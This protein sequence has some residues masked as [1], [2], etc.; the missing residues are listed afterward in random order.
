MASRDRI[1]IFDRNIFLPRGCD[2]KDLKY[3]GSVF[4]VEVERI[5]YATSMVANLKRNVV[6]RFKIY[7]ALKIRSC[8][9]EIV[10]PLTNLSR[11]E[12]PVIF[13]NT[14]AV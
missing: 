7:V 3:V 1:G 5:C 11:R 6:Y 14:T 9:L 2:L 10:E 12:G 13:E 8:S 4:V